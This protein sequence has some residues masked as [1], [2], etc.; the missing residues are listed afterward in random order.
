MTKKEN[1]GSQNQN[2]PQRGHFQEEFGAD[3]AGDNSKGTKRNKDQRD[4][5]KQN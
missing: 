3:I 5:S 4:N 1:R 2:A